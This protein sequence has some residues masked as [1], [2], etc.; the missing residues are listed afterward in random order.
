[1]SVRTISKA[2]ALL[3]EAEELLETTLGHEPGYGD[4]KRDDVQRAWRKVYDAR[5]VTHDLLRTED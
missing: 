1:M 5:V 3:A 4:P 2:L